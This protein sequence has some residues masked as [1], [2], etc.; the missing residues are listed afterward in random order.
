M[1]KTRNLHRKK[2]SHQTKRFKQKGG[3]LTTTEVEL[4]QK[5]TDTLIHILG[6][7]SPYKNIWRTSVYEYIFNIDYKNTGLKNN[8]T[9]QTKA[10]VQ[11]VQYRLFCW[12]KDNIPNAVVKMPK[13][14]IFCRTLTRIDMKQL[15]VLQITNKKGT[16]IPKPGTYS[17]TSM[18]ANVNVNVTLPIDSVMFLKTNKDLY[19]LNIIPFLH[20]M[21]MQYKDRLGTILYGDT[22]AMDEVRNG[23]SAN[24]MEW[25][26]SYAL[27]KLGLN[28]IIQMDYV[29]NIQDRH[30]TTDNFF[31]KP[32]KQL[33]IPSTIGNLF[34]QVATHSIKHNLNQVFVGSNPSGNSYYFA[35]FGT[36]NF[37]EMV[38]WDILD[39]ELE[40]KR[41]N[42][43]SPHEQSLWPNNINMLKNDE[44]GKTVKDML[45]IYKL[46]KQ[47]YLVDIDNFSSKEQWTTMQDTVMTDAERLKKFKTK[48][49]M[50]FK[51]FR[52][53][54]Q[55]FV[56]YSLELYNNHSFLQFGLNLSNLEHIVF[57]HNPGIGEL[58]MKV[59]DN[60]ES[61]N[62]V[63]KL[64]QQIAIGPY[65]NSISELHKDIE[66]LNNFQAHFCDM[67]EK[68][69]TGELCCKLDAIP[70][71]EEGNGAFMKV[72]AD[73][74][75]NF[76]SNHAFNLF[77]AEMTKDLIHTMIHATNI[78]TQKIG[79]VLMHIILTYV[80]MTNIVY[81]IVNESDI[82][83]GDKEEEDDEIDDFV[84]T[85]LGHNQ[86]TQ[87]DKFIDSSQERQVVLTSRRIRENLI[88]IVKN[89]IT[90]NPTVDVTEI[91][92]LLEESFIDASLITLF[93]NIYLKG[94][95]SFKFLL[96]YEIE[97]EDDRAI[98]ERGFNR[99]YGW[100]N[101][102]SKIE[103]KLGA[104]SD[105]DCNCVINPHIGEKNYILISDVLNDNLTTY[106]SD[107][108][109]YTIKRRFYE[110]SENMIALKKLLMSNPLKL[111]LH[112]DIDIDTTTPDATRIDGINTSRMDH[113]DESLTNSF[114]FYSKGPMLWITDDD[115]KAVTQ[116]DLHRLMLN[117]PLIQL[118]ET[119]NNKLDLGTKDID[120]KTIYCTYGSSYVAIELID[121]S[122][123]NW[124]GL[125]RVQKWQDS[126]DGLLSDSL[127]ALYENVKYTHTNGIYDAKISNIYPFYGYYEVTF[128][129]QTNTY[130]EEMVDTSKLSKLQLKSTPT[131]GVY[132]TQR[133]EI[134]YY[135]TVN[136]DIR[137]ITSDNL[138]TVPTTD[139]TIS[140]FDFNQIV[141]SIEPNPVL[142]QIVGM[143]DQTT[144]VI[145]KYDLSN[146]RFDNNTYSIDAQY[147]APIK[148]SMGIQ[149]YQFKNSV[150]DLMVTLQDTI[151]G[152]RMA[153][154][155]KRQQRLALLS[156]LYYTFV[157]IPED[158]TN[159]SEDG[160]LSVLKFSGYEAEYTIDPVNSMKFLKEFFK[161]KLFDIDAISTFQLDAWGRIYILLLACISLHSNT[162]RGLDDVIV[163][164]NNWKPLVSEF[165]VTLSS[166]ITSIF[167]DEHGQLRTPP[168]SPQYKWTPDEKKKIEI[169]FI[170][171]FTEM[172]S[173]MYD[174]SI[175]GPA[176][177]MYAMQILMFHL[178]NDTYV[179][180]TAKNMGNATP[181][182]TLSERLQIYKKDI[183]K[184]GK[185]LIDRRP[186]FTN[187]KS[188]MDNQHVN[189]EEVLYAINKRGY[190]LNNVN[191]I[192]KY[193]SAKSIYDAIINK[194]QSPYD[195]THID[196]ASKDNIE[197]VL[198]ELP[199]AHRDMKYVGKSLYCFAVNND[200]NVLL[201]SLITVGQPTVSAWNLTP[202][203]YYTD[204]IS[205]TAK[206]ALDEISF[207]T[208][209]YISNIITIVPPVKSISIDTLITDL[210]TSYQTQFALPNLQNIFTS[211]PQIV[212]GKMI[213]VY[214]IYVEQTLSKKQ[215]AKST[216]MNE[217][218]MYIDQIFTRTISHMDIEMIKQQTQ[219][220]ESKNAELQVRKDEIDKLHYMLQTLVASTPQTDQVKSFSLHVVNA[221]G[222]YLV[223]IQNGIDAS[224]SNGA[225]QT[226]PF[227]APNAYVIDLP[228]LKQTIQ[229]LSEQLTI[230]QHNL[231]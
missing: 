43:A 169:F 108:L 46:T 123:V 213:S 226:N 158:F 181:L 7:N 196:I 62:A 56:L 69:A 139:L 97:K 90:L 154:V 86:S 41:F 221:V 121:I 136:S 129:D 4:I 53:A 173:I 162:I 174:S 111:K 72:K 191:I 194:D 210:S 92:E 37:P 185:E 203:V 201:R 1:V 77:V 132:K 228:Y 76:Y 147:L 148:W 75:N 199:L 134:I 119:E 9:L 68:C 32:S 168:V 8:P 74:T 212:V 224:L 71:C 177:P 198:S 211:L 28:G 155:L 171:V 125:E 161:M 27:N 14:T 31:F 223:N 65:H 180:T 142:C 107:D 50:I 133:V 144:Y 114:A 38:N 101:N 204:T 15:N 61:T 222:S 170:N 120:G 55:K 105:Y 5:Y 130:I 152:G 149:M 59:Y 214:N 39:L 124:G 80:N 202:P 93:C 96:N 146:S 94:G 19:Y 187:I 2:S 13:G 34:K 12:I 209:A 159:I 83:S 81:N 100:K 165:V 64:N 160:P 44:P 110:G 195:F 35:E 24:G 10:K 172:I 156:Q 117:M 17:N 128:N 137:I 47:N 26:T 190:D 145:N 60:I 54:K 153:K 141:T 40:F 57:Q 78:Y 118:Y 11:Q 217:Q 193:E 175:L 176:Y 51:T 167:A 112:I 104:P 115:D 85:L 58:A 183:A 82:Q 89:I 73:A 207:S 188:W 87:A 6:V 151:K 103:E 178:L 184:V 116:F 63:H 66:L 95:T 186:L 127:Y 99:L 138:M 229:F 122:V 231:S 208:F 230:A 216:N 135:G 25:A 113:E 189:V 106:M 182:N 84:M 219:E 150:H 45:D 143:I 140:L 164:N 88:F 33:Q 225:I 206:K 21:G 205:A 29:E 49:E 157:H 220:L 16:L 3:A 179:I 79:K 215:M 131:L 91:N 42:D 227:L 200:F 30:V 36:Y 70:K 22:S 218:K 52:K 48:K 102:T 192:L 163:M 126:I 20:L 67:K 197:G 109:Y 166:N 18:M 98:R 23:I